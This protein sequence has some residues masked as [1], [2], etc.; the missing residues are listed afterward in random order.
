M[1]LGMFSSSSCD[2][3]C[4][5]PNPNPK[6]FLIMHS[7]S[8]GNYLVVKVCYPDCTNYEGVKILVYWGTSVKKLNIQGSLDPHFSENKEYVSPIAR[9]EPTKY[10]W[11][12][13]VSYARMVK[14][15]ER[16]K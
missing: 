12:S 15:Q 7:F 9:F 3:G 1:G 5:F 11:D 13:A 16:V 10:G 6:N 8:I 2:D 4:R 14:T